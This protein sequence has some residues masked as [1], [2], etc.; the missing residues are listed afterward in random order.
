MQIIFSFLDLEKTLREPKRKSPIFAPKVAKCICRKSQYMF[1]CI[2]F[3]KLRVVSAFPL[4]QKGLI[5]VPRT[6][7]DQQEQLQL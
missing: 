5:K 2:Y 1:E 4:C 3:K 6:N 7:L